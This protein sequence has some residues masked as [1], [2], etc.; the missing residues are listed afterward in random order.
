L[1]IIIALSAIVAGFAL[2]W[3]SRG[4]TTWCP[5]CGNRLA[6][7]ECPRPIAGRFPQGRVTKEAGQ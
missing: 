3:A 5:S 1:L 2:G 7:T 6:C 4:A